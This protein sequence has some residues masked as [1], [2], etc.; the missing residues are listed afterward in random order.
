MRLTS[1][2]PWLDRRGRRQQLD[3][4]IRKTKTAYFGFQKVSEQEKQGRIA[5]HFDK[6]ARKYDL[7]NSLLSF[8]IHHAWK[9]T[10]VRALSLPAGAKVIDVCGGTGDLAILAAR[11]AG[12]AGRVVVFDINRTMMAYGRPKVLDADLGDRVEFV[13]GNAEAIAFPD[14]HF[15]A[16]MVGFGIRN[17][18]HMKTAFA[19][20]HRVLKPGGRL[21]CLEFSKPVWPPFRGLYDLYSFYIMP[22]L[23]QLIAGNRAGYLLLTESIRLFPTPGEMVSILTGIGFSGVRYRLLTNGIAAV[24]VGEKTVGESA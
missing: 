3:E 20:M 9:R 22:A 21:M 10:A 23:G 5:R 6:V 7:M 18:T 4:S 8:G 24:H 19:E 2:S 16:A 11:A 14:N 12:S 15:D 13:Q 17:V 1:R